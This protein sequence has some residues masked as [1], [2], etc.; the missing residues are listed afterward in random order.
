VSARILDIIERASPNFEPRPKGGSIDMLVLHYTGMPG[1]EDALRRLADPAARVSAHYLIDEDGS[2]FRLVPEEFRAWHAGASCWA[3]RRNVNDVSIGVELVNPGHEFGYRDFPDA[4]MAALETLARDILE[5]H[6]I[7]P[8]RVLGHSDIAPG[9]KQDPG[10]RFDWARLAGAGIGIWPRADESP[11]A[12]GS[13]GSSAGE[14][15]R[16][17]TRFGYDAGEDEGL[18]LRARLALEAFQR[19]FRPARVDGR[20]DPET[21]HR[22]QALNALLP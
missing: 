6:S 1:C 20:L 17:L 4:Q 13:S 16:L 3:G 8:E 15:K 22:L 5:R 12:P 11:P 21:F 19:H 7:P 9:R 18:D 14:M 10:E 2:V